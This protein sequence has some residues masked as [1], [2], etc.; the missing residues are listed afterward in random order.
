MY[1]GGAGVGDEKRIKRCRTDDAE[2]RIR[3]D[4]GVEMSPG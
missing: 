2:A 4:G 3:D 1:S